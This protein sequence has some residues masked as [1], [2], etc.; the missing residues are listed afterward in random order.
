MIR[1]IIALI[2]V[3]SAVAT[4]QTDKPVITE[5]DYA[6]YRIIRSNLM[7]MM[8]LKKTFCLTDREERLYS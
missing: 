5:S 7:L 8:Q 4:A 2:L 3:M 6:D 1:Y